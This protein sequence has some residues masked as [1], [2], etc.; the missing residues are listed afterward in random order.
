M[1]NMWCVRNG[2][3]LF[4]CKGKVLP[5]PETYSYLSTK[6]PTLQRI[7]ISCVILR[8]ILNKGRKVGK[9]NQR[10]CPEFTT[11]N[12]VSKIRK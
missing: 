4:A 1:S 9:G 7:S 6:S 2:Q 5:C 11:F 8:L 10:R 12:G 3:C